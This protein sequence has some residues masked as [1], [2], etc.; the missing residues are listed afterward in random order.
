MCCAL[1]KTTTTETNKLIVNK[2][3]KHT[4]IQFIGANNQQATKSYIQAETY[5]E[6]ITAT[7]K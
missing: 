3:G 5:F 4:S 6:T 2:R 7:A 1:C